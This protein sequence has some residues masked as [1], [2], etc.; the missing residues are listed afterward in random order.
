MNGTYPEAWS[1]VALPALVQIPVLIPVFF[2]LV[3]GNSDYNSPRDW[4][5]NTEGEPKGMDGTSLHYSWSTSLG[6]LTP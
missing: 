5:K 3:F 6:K 1:E 2:G 4:F